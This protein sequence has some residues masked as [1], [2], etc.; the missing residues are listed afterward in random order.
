MSSLIPTWL[1]GLLPQGERTMLG[2][3]CLLVRD[4]QQAWRV[5]F[6]E[7]VEDAYVLQREALWLMRLRHL[8]IPIHETLSLNKYAVNTVLITSYLEGQP[9]ALFWKTLD[10]TQR[11][12]WLSQSL[13]TLLEDIGQLHAAHVVHGDI[14]PSNILCLPS[15]HACLVDFANARRVGEPWKERGMLQFTPSFHY[16]TPSP[17]AR[18]EHDYYAM[19]ICIT[20]LCEPDSLDECLTVNS[21]LKL[22]ELKSTDWGMP[23]DVKTILAKW[24]SAIRLDL[25][26]ESDALTEW[27]S[28]SETVSATE[29]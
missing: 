27:S 11:R 14:K 26:A 29:K 21:L 9:A 15:L 19:L 5:K 8:D 22:V 1:D 28:A 18:L 17:L 24:I 4:D 3:R 16:P 13:P 7:T 25:G 12:Q 10:T 2:R 6:G 23:D 20:L